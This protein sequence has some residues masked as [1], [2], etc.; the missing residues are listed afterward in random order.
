MHELEASQQKAFCIIVYYQ[1]EILHAL[2]DKVAL[3][4]RTHSE[5]GTRKEGLD[6]VYR[7]C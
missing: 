5:R 6:N 1:V 4:M 2:H 7:K 3:L